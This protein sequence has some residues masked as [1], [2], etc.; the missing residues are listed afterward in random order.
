VQ[1][2][3]G[4][5]PRHA[6]EVGRHRH[7]GRPLQ[8]FERDLSATLS[9]RFRGAFLGCLLGDAVGRSFEMMSASDGRI[10][11]A[12][13]RERSRANETS[14][15]RQRS[16]IGGDYTVENSCFRRRTSSSR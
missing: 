5:A 8:H 12:G 4:R 6:L 10:G 1:P 14:V 2:T 3:E 9:S 13:G 7:R 11:S 15:A 16:G